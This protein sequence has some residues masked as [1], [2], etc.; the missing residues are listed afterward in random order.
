MT[1]RRR[2]RRR[3]T[4]GACRGRSPGA[5]RPPSRPRA[6]RGGPCPGDYRMRR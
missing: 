2:G 3:S 1:T 4:C 5:V 6:G